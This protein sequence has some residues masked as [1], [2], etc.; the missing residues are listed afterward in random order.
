MIYT[1]TLNP[2]L[3]YVMMVNEL[4]NGET[5][6]SQAEKI[7]P[8]GKGFNVSRIL[9]EFGIANKAIGLA[10]GFSGLEIDRLLNEKG[11]DHELIFMAEGFSRI[12]IKLKGSEETEI[13]GA[14]PKADAM[15]IK[16]LKQILDTMNEDDTAALC[17]S[18]CQGIDSSTFASILSLLKSKGVR[19]IV[20]M[21]NE[22][23]LNSLAYEPW[24]IK[25]NLSELCELWKKPIH[26]L[27]EL[28]DAMM[29]CSQRKAQNVLVSLGKDGAVLLDVQQRLYYCSAPAGEVKNSVGA[30]DSMLAGFLTAY[31]QSQSY[32]KALRVGVACGSATAFNDDLAKL[33]QIMSYYEGL[34]IRSLNA[35]ESRLAE[36][37]E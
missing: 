33:K 32:E 6:R 12:N 24:L 16:R 34:N 20:D 35:D 36:I 5:N 8:G 7:Y 14:G 4:K 11:I 29:F 18:L 22:A 15:V 9:N 26:S 21:S 1:I 28:R 30:G 13:N 37:V 3:D 25:P 17:G 31:M 2:S 10:A 27:N 23:L 19:L